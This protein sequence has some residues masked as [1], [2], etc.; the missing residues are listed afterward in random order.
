MSQ[1]PAYER[2]PLLATLETRVLHA[3]EEKGRPFVVLEDTIFY[4]EG[5]GQ[6]CD[7]G[8]VNGRPVLDVQKQEGEIRHYT[9]G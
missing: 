6:P 3:G 2:D 7:L 4:P 5:G 8:T 1:P 9:E